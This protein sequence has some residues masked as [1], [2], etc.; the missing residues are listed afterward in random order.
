MNIYQP[1]G[2]LDIGRLNSLPAN[3]YIIIGSRQ[4]G[5]TY[6]CFKHIM[7]TYVKNDIPFIFM[8]RTGLELLG[9]LSDN[10]FDKGYNPDHGTAYKFDK[11][12]GI[13]PDSRLN[14][15]DGLNDDKII[16]S[17]FSLSGLVSNRGFNGDPYQCIMYDE[18][19][20]EKIKKRMNGE[21]EAFEN[22][23]MTINSVRE[24]KGRPAVKAWLLSN[25]N[26]I[27]SP[28]LEAF[29]LVN[30][31]TRM[32]NRGQEFCFLPEQKICV[33]NVAESKIS[34]QLAKTAL[35]KAVQDQQ[36]RGMA[37]HNTFAYDDFSCIG[38]EPINEYRLLVSIGNINI[39][40][41]KAHDLY[42]VTLH[43]RGTGKSFPDNL[44]GRH[45]FL[46]NY[47]WLQDK[48]IAERVTFENYELKLKLFEYLKIKG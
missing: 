19:I 32:Q 36:F 47:I 48:V 17:A 5:K 3:F 1:D 38:T 18:F 29:G 34:E 45:R 4:V 43:R 20:P 7:N 28:I 26:S 46:Q 14:I 44:S 11:I 42:Y 9:C 41:H 39:Y 6:S 10:P 33:V 15:V 16:G 25:S 31:I 8:R 13:R 22:A 2:W 24:L 40:E 23:Y 27:E 12:K 35:F 21:K 37:L 30:T